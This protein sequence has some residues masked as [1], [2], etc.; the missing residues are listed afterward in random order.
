M[1]S[2][3]S[4][5]WD[6][7]GAA[8]TRSI[9]L[10]WEREVS[11]GVFVIS[12]LFSNIQTEHGRGGPDGIPTASVSYKDTGGAA[13][14]KR[15]MQIWSMQPGNP[16]AQLVSLCWLFS[17]LV[18]SEINPSFFS[19]EHIHTF[20]P[21]LSSTWK[22]GI[23]SFQSL[24]GW[25]ILE[26]SMT[27]P[28]AINLSLEKNKVVTSHNTVFVVWDMWAPCTIYI[29]CVNTEWSLHA[30]FSEILFYGLE[31]LSMIM[32]SSNCYNWDGKCFSGENME[33]KKKIMLP[34]LVL[35]K[36]LPLS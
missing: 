3:A 24:A 36:V 11:S 12:A 8:A 10:G 5:W 29:C 6:V 33:A 19:F 9:F 21:S 1:L 22:C 30:H 15:T 7:S 16:V 17:F 32:F 31:K 18:H 20:P 27:H 26:V 28:R 2:H 4:E 14:Q 23:S 35:I 25:V 13:P 34:S